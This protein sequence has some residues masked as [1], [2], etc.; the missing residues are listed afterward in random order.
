MLDRARL[1]YFYPDLNYDTGSPKAMVQFIN[2]LDRRV[3]TPVYCAE[4]KGP[5][6]EILEARGVEIIPWRENML[7]LQRPFAAVGAIRRQAKLLKQWKIDLIHANCFPWNSDLLVAAR[8]LRIPVILH[9]HNPLDV[10][11]RNLTRFAAQ[12][13][14]F[15]SGAVMQSCG[16]FQRVAAKSAVLHNIIDVDF[17]SR[18]HSIRSSLGLGEGDIAIGTVAQIV[19]RKGIDILLETARALLRERKDLVFLIVGPQMEREE[20]FGRRMVAIG[21]EPAF[22]G[23]VRFLGSRADIPDL[24]ASLDLFLLPS[25]AEPMGIVIIEA[26][27]AGL[28]V[29][30]SKVGGI[31]E[32]LSSPEIGILVDP[33]TPEAFA[34]AIQEVLSRPDRGRDMGVKGRESL[35]GRFDS[36]T[37]R[38]RL[39]R[40]Y[41]DV[42]GAT[43]FAKPRT[44]LG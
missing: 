32:I 20:E 10:P 18:G 16:H 19:H 8:L 6:T 27:A 12:K 40:I 11:F 15:C 34:H 7:N 5:L 43:V 31:P 17:W 37:G 25:R 1:L 4:G 42:L 14:L 44:K 21:Q 30:A 3:F 35:T 2:L 23:R 41:F 28:P 39:Q 33:L 9:V 24:M 13:V 29:I 22:G 38:Q 26:M 36:A